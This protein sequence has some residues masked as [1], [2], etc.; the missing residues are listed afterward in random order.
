MVQE[1]RERYIEVIFDLEKNSPEEKRVH[2]KQIAEA[3]QVKE[4]SVTEMINRLNE[5]KLV[6]YRPYHGVKLT[7]KGREMGKKLDHRHRVLAEFFKSLGVE[8]EIA[9]TDACRIEHVVNEK[10]ITKLKSFV[11]FITKTSH[12]HAT[13]EHFDHYDKTG[14]FLCPKNND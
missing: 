4:A 6:D 10:T 14:E 2:T 8:N 11:D 13:L 3:L 1:T 7:E 9:E 5:K 12:S